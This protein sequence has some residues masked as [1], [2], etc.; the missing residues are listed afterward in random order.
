MNVTAKTDD[1]LHRKARHRVVNRGLS[2]SGWSAEVFRKEL[3][4]DKRAENRLLDTLAVED[5]AQKAFEI[6]R[7]ASVARVLAFSE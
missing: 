2:L 4:T 1:K 3:A 6:P 5:G 7:D